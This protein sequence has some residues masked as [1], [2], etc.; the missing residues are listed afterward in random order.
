[1][2]TTRLI[3]AVIAYGSLVYN[4]SSRA[5]SLLRLKRVII[6]EFQLGSKNNCFYQLE[7]WKDY[8][9]TLERIKEAQENEEGIPLLL[10]IHKEVR[11][12]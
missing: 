5:S 12:E 8:A 2:G 4:E 3:R 1:M 10:W 9:T 7:F 6:D 11:N